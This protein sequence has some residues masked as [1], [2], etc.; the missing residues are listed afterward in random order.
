MID[1]T[2]ERVYEGLDIIGDIHGYYDELIDLLSAMGYHKV[3]GVWQHPLR[4]AVFIGDFVS[5]GPDTRGVLETIRLMTDSGFAYA[6]LGNHELNMIGYFTNG[7]DG[8]ALYKPPESNKKQ[9]D[10][11]KAQFTGEKPLLKSYVKWLR[12]LPFSLEFD[13]LRIAHAYWSDAH[14]SLISDTLAG[15][16]LKKWMIKEI[17]SGK[18]NFAHAVRQTTRGIELNLP[19]NLII[20]DSKN[21][22]RK[23]FRIKWW[24]EPDGKTFREL[25]F[26][27][28]FLLP[29]YTVP[30]QVLQ[31]FEV[32]N[33]NE[34]AF[35]F[36]HYCAGQDA[37]VLKEN[38]C[39][40]DGC[41]ANKGKLLAYRWDGERVLTP[42]KVTSAPV[43]V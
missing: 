41:V 32:Y 40:I 16:K 35:I 1:N 36:G 39:C 17:F 20:K 12:T 5:R 43:V 24:E 34:P 18:S 2:G 30:Q 23:N 9:L 6:V 4:C 37:G 8:R 10:A 14:I 25:S 27:N 22:N 29:D 11:I 26:G 28:R 3:G 31:P 42:A 38:L 33:E 21:V 15:G 19:D 13:G 7:K